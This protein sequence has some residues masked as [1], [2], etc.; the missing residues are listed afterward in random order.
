[1]S[2]TFGNLLFFMLVIGII[3]FISEE[4]KKNG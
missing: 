2:V 1:M 3:I 4:R